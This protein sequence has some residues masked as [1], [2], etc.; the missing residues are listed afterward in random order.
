MNIH[1]LHEFTEL[2]RSL[3]FTETAKSLNITQSALSKHILALEKEF[4]TELF[5]RSRHGVR[6]SGAGQLLFEKSVAIVS[7]Y[8]EAHDELRTF[9][10]Q[11][12]ITVGGNISDSDIAPLLSMTATI[13]RENRRRTLN[14]NDSSER[15]FIQMIN[16][17][18]IDVAVSFIVRSK[19]EEAG[20]EYRPL[21]SLPL[22]AIMSTNNP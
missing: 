16:S 11:P 2:A 3:N 20:L 4:D 12:P 19:I 21:F 10:A 1:V 5:D 17:G 8:Q 9:R 14:F 22:V 13:M 7:I 6:L 15:N 18:K